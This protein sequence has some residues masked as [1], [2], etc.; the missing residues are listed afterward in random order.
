MNKNVLLYLS[1]TGNHKKITRATLI[2][3]LGEVEVDSDQEMKIPVKAVTSNVLVLPT[4]LTNVMWVMAQFHFN[5][6]TLDGT[7]TLCFMIYISF[8]KCKPSSVYLEDSSSCS[9]LGKEG[10]ETACATFLTLHPRAE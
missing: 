4:P 5:G 8:R 1:F 2:E 3:A 9:E 6:S 10:H 7:L